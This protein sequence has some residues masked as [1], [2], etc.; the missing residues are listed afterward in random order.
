MFEI[1]RVS[2]QC[3]PADMRPDL[4]MR[5]RMLSSTKPTFLLVTIL[6]SVLLVPALSM[7][8]LAE[9]SQPCGCAHSR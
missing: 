7:I 1:H 9:S 5:P 3:R 6:R 8:A 4:R 2:D